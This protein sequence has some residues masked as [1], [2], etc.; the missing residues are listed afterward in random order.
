M[1]KLW[2]Y[3]PHSDDLI[4]RPMA[5]HILERLT[6]R[7]CHTKY[8]QFKG[9]CN[10]IYIDFTQSSL[11]P[12]NLILP[13]SLLYLTS[14]LILIELLIWCIINRYHPRQIVFRLGS[15]GVCLWVDKHRITIA[16]HY[17]SEED[18]L[19]I[20]PRKTTSKHFSL[21]SKDYALNIIFALDHFHLNRK[22]LKEN[23]SYLVSAG[24]ANLAY[25]APNRIDRNI[26]S[27]QFLLPL[28]YYNLPYT[29]RESFSCIKTLESRAKR[30][31]VTGTYHS[32]EEV[33]DEVSDLQFL[34]ANSI[35]YLRRE[36]AE[37]HEYL[38]LNLVDVVCT[39]YSIGIRSSVEHRS[40]LSMPNSTRYNNHVFAY[41]PSERLGIL[42]QGTIE[43]MACGC[44][45]LIEQPIYDL[46]PRMLKD[47]LIPFNPTKSSLISKVNELYNIPQSNLQALS[48]K[49]ISAANAYT[50]KY[51]AKSFLFGSFVKPQ[52]R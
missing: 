2:I 17:F 14:P 3:N 21:T 39:N 52:T 50:T 31:L 25:A 12:A 4:F 28:N 42:A 8:A 24:F 36:L 5:K 51:Q 6:G 48:I 7:K 40:Y 27:N 23:V 38:S 1:S 46:L 22:L 15:K 18:F 41:C 33:K 10:G 19:L 32:I 9:S 47:A 34:L 11:L 16:K 30:L 44:I 26:D 35:H 49:S 13:T 37:D 29:I 43:A 45:T 20:F